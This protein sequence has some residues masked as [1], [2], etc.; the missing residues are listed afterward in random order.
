[1]D[2][3]SFMTFTL[4]LVVPVPLLLLEAALDSDISVSFYHLRNNPSLLVL[5]T[6]LALLSSPSSVR[7]DCS[8]SLRE[9]VLQRFCPQ[10]LWRGC[11][12][13]GVRGP[14]CSSCSK[15]HE[16]FPSSCMK[17]GGKQ[18]HVPTQPKDSSCA[19]QFSCRFQE[20]LTSSLPE[21]TGDETF[22]R[23]H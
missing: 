3:D 11:A 10:L 20:P 12:G 16:P 9:P 5:S 17:G 4:I 14:A 13:A 8:G 21:I 22:F 15:N 2:A 6:P 18:D 7:A 1:M 19:L 23:K